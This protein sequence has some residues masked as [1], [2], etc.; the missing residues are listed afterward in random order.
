[1]AGT[2]RPSSSS[3]RAPAPGSARDRDR[4]LGE[5]PFVSVLHPDDHPATASVADA[6][7]TAVGA[8]ARSLGGLGAFESISIRGQAPGQTT[9]FVD[10][11][12][13]SRLA[14]VT[15]DLGRYALDAFGEVDLYRGAVPIEL[16]ARASAARSI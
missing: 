16:G 5:T 6:V 15:T 1:M 3:A 4:A 2:A 14:A 10:G 8:Q 7:A 12:P 9:V 13:L 11:V